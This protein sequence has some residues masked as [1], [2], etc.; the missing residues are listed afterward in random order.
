MKKTVLFTFLGCLFFLGGISPVW[1]G[2]S[3]PL[4][5]PPDQQEQA[6]QLTKKEIRQQERLQKK[7]NWLDRM[8]T[9][10][11]EKAQ[12]KEKK[13]G[14]KI[15]DSLDEYL[16]L[17][18]IFFIAAVVF[19]ILASLMSGIAVLAEVTAILSGASAVAAVIFF[20]L[21][22]AENV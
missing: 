2:A 14:R 1:A 19:A 22:L 17:T 8:I 5:T 13:S 9:K 11:V 3:T 15:F 18:L 4:L 16:R 20:I 21:W 12:E 6:R 7:V 10:K